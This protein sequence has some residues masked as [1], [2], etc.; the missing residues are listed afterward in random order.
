MCNALCRT[1]TLAFL[2]IWP[3]VASAT[4]Y[5]AHP[6]TVV[7][8]LAAGA[9]ADFATRLIARELADRLRQTFVVENRPGAGA[10]IGTTAVARAPNDGHTLLLA[11]SGALVINPTLYKQLS[12]DV[13][14]DFTPIAHTT[15][16]PLI[17]VTSPD[18]PAHGVIEWIATAR[19]HPGQLSFASSG[20][21]SSNH[22]AAELFQR[23]AGV[24]LIHVPYRNSTLALNDVLSAR[25][26]MMFS[27]AGACLG[28]IAAG[29]LRALGVSTRSRLAALPQV[30]PLAEAGLPGFGAK[31]WHMLVG[32][33]GMPEQAVH[34]LNREI[35]AVMGQP[36]V[37]QQLAARG[38]QPVSSPDPESLRV[39]LDGEMQRTAEV[40]RRLG[41]AGSQ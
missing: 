4:D 22:L 39:F 34:L 12:Y 21:G 6:V 1:L 31:S 41:L 11:P 35:S 3:V 14:R 32:P 16:V 37:Q 24:S 7:V 30:P 17:L 28:L 10:I 20:N 33:A 8:P 5:P 2:V 15:D 18:N 23:M 38:L 13:Q 9:S 26:Q 19:S 27:D 36:E 40:L 25:V 29:K